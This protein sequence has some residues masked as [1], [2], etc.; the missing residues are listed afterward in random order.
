MIITAVLV[1]A[2]YLTSKYLHEPSH[3]TCKPDYIDNGKVNCRTKCLTGRFALKDQIDCHP[4]LNCYDIQHDIH[5]EENRLILTGVVKMVYRAKWKNQDII[6]AKPRTIEFI[7]DFQEN[8]KNLEAYS[9]NEHLVQLVGHCNGTVVLT[10]YHKFGSALNF[11]QV[12]T[13]ES[14]ANFDNVSVRIRLCRDYASILNFLHHKD[15]Q[16]PRVMCDSSSLEKTLTQYLLTNDLGLVLADLDAIPF[17][18]RGVKCGHKELRGNFVAPE[19]KWPFP[20]LPFNDMQMPLYDEKSD[21]WK[22]PDVC[23]WF[24]GPSREADIV[25]YRLYHI[26]NSCKSLDTSLRPSA[27][28]LLKEYQLLLDEYL[29]A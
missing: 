29:E 28:D 14:I 7:E 10:E 9:P 16:G 18:G 15:P 1:L 20:N 21:I 26:H 3:L 23:D 5:Q 6:L 4:W 24:L 27:A 25:R 13:E 2:A 19:Q 8:L 12:I 17:V 22:V 11:K